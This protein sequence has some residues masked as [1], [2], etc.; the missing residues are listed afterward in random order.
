MLPPGQLVHDR[1]LYLASFGAALLSALVLSK[2]AAGPTTFGIPRRLLVPTLAIV[3]LS[4]Y[5]TAD[6]SS[7][8]L[9]DYTLFQHSYQLAPSNIV[10][11]VNYAIAVARRGDYMSAMPLL[12]GVLY[13]DP[14]NWLANYNLGRVFYDMGLYP[15][16]EGRFLVVQRLFPANADNYLQLGM[17]DI[18]TNRPELAEANI[19]RA[20]E[21]QPSETA[22]RFSLGVA[23]EVEGKCDEARAE[24]TKTLAIDPTFPKAEEQMTKCNPG[25][26]QNGSVAGAAEARSASAVPVAP[27]AQADAVSVQ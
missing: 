12:D 19:R 22:F 7:Y 11:R 21:L 8:W 24:F 1:Y 20:V 17:V 9:D 27:T 6:A 5:A 26:A 14:N 18:K 15:A 25:A 23:L 3:V 2:L 16:A 4:C 10:A 13:E